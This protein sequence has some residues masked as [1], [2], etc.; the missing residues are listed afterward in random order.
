[1]LGAGRLQLFQLQL[2]LLDLPLNFFRRTSEH[3]PP[4]LGNE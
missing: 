4:Q 3:H 2:Q 1:M